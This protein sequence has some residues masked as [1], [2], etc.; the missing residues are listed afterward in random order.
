[1]PRLHYSE[2]EE[3]SEA[4]K[5]YNNIKPKREERRD[6]RRQLRRSEK[7]FLRD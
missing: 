7:R 5:D 4:E 3:F 2:I 1:M 6:K